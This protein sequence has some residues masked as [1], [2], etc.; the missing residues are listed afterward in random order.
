MALGDLADEEDEATEVEVLD[1]GETESLPEA[2]VPQSSN[3]LI[4]PVEDIDKVVQLYDQFEE[5]KSKLLD[6]GDTTKIGNN[7]HVNKSGWRKIATA[8]NL[9]AE[10]VETDMW[11]ENGVV[12]ARAIARATA[13][14]GKVSTEVGMCA[15]NE[16][17]YMEAGKPRDGTQPQDHPDYFRV[18]GKWRRLKEPKEVNDHNILA[19]AATRAKNRAISDCVGGGEVSAEEM[20]AEDVFD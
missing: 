19:V 13:P 16:S 14:N 4:Q 10:V 18:D 12:K 17:N 7:L 3:T 8:F 6:K 15:S 2:P 11:V 20:T 1:E 9:S 5:I